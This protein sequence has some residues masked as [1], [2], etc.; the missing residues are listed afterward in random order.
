MG[1]VI[2]ITDQNGAS[3]EK[4]TKLATRKTQLLVN[5]TPSP[6]LFIKINDV[7]LRV[8]EIISDTNSHIEFECQIEFTSDKRQEA[9]DLLKKLL[10]LGFSKKPQPKQNKTKKKK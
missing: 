5:A 3:N 4:C 9:D 2:L 8:T 1:V 6:G 7:E 10:K